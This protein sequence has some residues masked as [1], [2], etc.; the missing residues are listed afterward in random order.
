MKLTALRQTAAALLLLATGPVLAADTPEYTLVLKDHQ[1]VPAEL[2]IPADTKVKLLVRND[3]ATPAEFESHSL[4]REKIIPANAT[5]TIFVG[6]LKPGE[7]EFFDEFH[8]ATTRGKL[9]V[10]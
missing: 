3:D 4:N 9:I 10:K 7:Y 5:V 6:P 8:E 2:S 1:F